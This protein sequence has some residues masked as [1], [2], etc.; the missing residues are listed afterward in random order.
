MVKET[1]A[2]NKPPLQ[3]PPPPPAGMTSGVIQLNGTVLVLATVTFSEAATSDF[4]ACLYVS[5]PFSQGT[6]KPSSSSFKL[7][8]AFTIP[9]TPFTVNFQT[10]YRNRFGVPPLGAKVFYRCLLVNKLSG[11]SF[12]A[13]QLSVTTTSI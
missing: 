3:L 8:Q 4:L 2:R 9:A 13:G 10:S 6:M 11:Q 1:F 12:N 7:I 5:F